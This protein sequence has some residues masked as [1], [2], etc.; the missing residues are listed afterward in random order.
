MHVAGHESDELLRS[1]QDN[2]ADEFVGI[3]LEEMRGVVIFP[4]LK[5]IEAGEPRSVRTS[6]GGPDLGGRR[7]S[8]PVTIDFSSFLWTL[9]PLCRRKGLPL[10]FNGRLF[11]RGGDQTIWS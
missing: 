9:L 10:H 7:D 4:S 3:L 6:R 11:I 2:V 1:E 5:N 8:F